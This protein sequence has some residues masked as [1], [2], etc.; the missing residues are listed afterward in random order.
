ML[1]DLQLEPMTVGRILDRTFRL[2]S[3]HF[4]TFVVVGALVQAPLFLAGLPIVRASDTLVWEM[5][6]ELAGNADPE[7][8]VRY[9]GGLCKLL[10]LALALQFVAHQLANGALV[11][12]VSD[13]YIGNEPR[14]GTAFGRVLPLMPRL[15]ASAALVMASV[16]VGFFFCFVPGVIVGCLLCVTSQAI[17]VEGLGPFAA[18]RRSWRLVSGNLGR[19]F[20]L[21]F[22]V[23]AISLVIVALSGGLA[24]VLGRV[25]GPESPAGVVA[26]QVLGLAA[27]VV[28][29]PIGSA[30]FCLFYYDLRIRKEGF[31]LEMLARSMRS[32]L[33]PPHD[34]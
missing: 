13:A 5:Q 21:G 16:S 15:L 24:E 7:V 8:L 12:C 14:S 9:L 28:A 31:D 27:R 10:A 34:M 19:A 18:F 25:L 20:G 3:T 32:E 4:T 1:D 30:A 22:T 6:R 33:P 2:Y 26:A 23:F 29:L 17:V 11:K